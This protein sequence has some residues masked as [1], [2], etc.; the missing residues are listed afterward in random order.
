MDR[1]FT[2]KHKVSNNNFF[3]YIFYKFT[4]KYNKEL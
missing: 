3:I 1:L 4:Q 2:I